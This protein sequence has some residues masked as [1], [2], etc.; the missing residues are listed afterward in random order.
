MSKCTNSDIGA[1]LHAYELNALS[2]EN[3]ECF[4]THLLECKHCFE[5][6]KSFEREANLLVS[7][8]KVKELIRKSVVEESQES[9]SFLKKLWRF[10]WPDTLLIF[11]PALAYLLIL[12][13][14]FPT[15]Y[16]LR[17][18]AETETG[19]EIRPVQII[20]LTPFRS[21]GE[22]VF[23]I[24]LGKDGLISFV[25]EG[26]V[27]GKSYQVLIKS[28]DDRVIFQDD[29]FNTFD[30]YANGRLLLPLAKMK[31][32]DYRLTI[33]DPQADAPLNKRE[34][35]FRIEN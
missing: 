31:P 3:T 15:Y 18:V 13:L 7:D 26:A 11:K 24:S 25:F 9:E 30:E 32:G 1:L 34:Y 6:L 29:V 10:I 28:E 33:T 8:Q 27:V 23:K 22:G 5:Q 2:E 21:A 17:K 4:E 35:T 16:G 14:I 20:N 12:I 19:T